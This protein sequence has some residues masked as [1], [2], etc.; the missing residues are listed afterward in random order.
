MYLTLGAQNIEFARIAHAEKESLINVGKLPSYWYARVVRVAK[1][2]MTPLRW[3]L[4]T[5]WRI[6][7]SS[8]SSLS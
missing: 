2:Y 6:L 3:N 4:K 5:L 8:F 7:E 1:L